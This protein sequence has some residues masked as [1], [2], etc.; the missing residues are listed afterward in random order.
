MCGDC[1]AGCNVGAKNT[2]ALTYLPD[3]VAHGADVFA[4]IKVVSVAR[5]AERWLLRAEGVGGARGTPHDIRAGQVILAAGALGSTEILLRSRDRGLT[6][7]DRLGEGFSG[8]GDI[9]A[10]GMGAKERVHGI[11]VGYPRRFDGPA[12]G[13]SVSG[14]IE[15]V[16][17]RLLE[18]GLVLQEGVLPSALA[19]VLP[20]IFLPGGRLLGA[21]E[22]LIKGVYE[23]P[24]AHL[25]TFFAVSHDSAGGRLSLVDDRLKLSW[26]GVA[27]EPVFQRLDAAME[28]AVKAVGGRYVKSP[29]AGTSVGSKPATAH[30]LG[31]A[32]MAADASGGVV[33]HAGRVF[34]GGDAGAQVH[35]GLYVIDGSIL[36]RS[37]GVNP[38]LTITA[39]AERA[40]ILMARDRNLAYDD[41]ERAPDAALQALIPGPVS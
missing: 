5:E 10:F 6:L 4:Q 24:L 17:E 37:L 9:I 36:P 34:N 3:A 23:G 39:L 38:L 22:S 26:P 33:D 14:Q 1:C 41:R 28:Q 30:P 15:I 35:P 29:L 2:L 32:R 8:N 25:Q 19:P 31:G 40:L 18:N 11:G 16:D 7:S 21:L 12:V 13:A 27:D 20:M